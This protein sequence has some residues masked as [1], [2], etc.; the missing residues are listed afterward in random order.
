MLD[1]ISDRTAW[2]SVASSN[3]KIHEI[4]KGKMHQPPW[5]RNFLLKDNIKYELLH[6][7]FLR[8]NMYHEPVWSPDGTQIAC[9]HSYSNNESNIAI[10]DQRHG[11]LRLRRRRDDDEEEIHWLAHVNVLD[12][13]FL[14]ALKFS[15]D[16]NF[17]VSASSND[18]FVRIWD[19]SNTDGYYQYQQLQEW[20]ILNEHEQLKFSFSSND[21]F[22]RIWDH[23]NTDGYYQYQQLQRQER[24]IVHEL[25]QPFF[26]D[27]GVLHTEESFD[28][29]PCCK[30]VAVLF[31]GRAL[32][33]DIHDNGKTIKSI[34]LP[35]NEEGNEILFSNKVGHHSIFIRSWDKVRKNCSIK[36]WRP[37]DGRVGTVL[38]TIETGCCNAVDYVCLSCDRSKIAISMDVKGCTDGGI[39]QRGEEQE[40]SDYKV[41]LYSYD[42]EIESTEN[43]LVLLQ[44]FYSSSGT[45][46][47]TPDDKYLNYNNKNGSAF[48][49]ISTGTDITENMKNSFKS[50]DEIFSFSPVGNRLIVYNPNR[51][52]RIVYGNGYRI[53]S[54]WESKSP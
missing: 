18:G 46:I 8:R 4:S 13:I 32:L 26:Q 25:E 40:C 42:T 54:Y 48:M 11:Q 1:F 15:P 22:V 35:E 47:F 5:P 31:Y 30:Y 41:M 36:I 29:S 51:A 20:N 2:E 3:R 17:L 52:Y 34:L 19:Y 39:Q 21:G 16:G 10:F 49:E 37:Y 43:I 12:D 27:E 6:Q 9:I 50:S 23:N 14:P 33:K 38:N 24:N 53:A 45:I 44:T 28:I 7:H